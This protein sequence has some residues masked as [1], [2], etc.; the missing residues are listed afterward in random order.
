MTSDHHHED[1]AIVAALRDLSREIIIGNLWSK[2]REDFRI[3]FVRKFQGTVGRGNT[4]APK[5]PGT[6]TASIRELT[7]F[8]RHCNESLAK[9]LLAQKAREPTTS[10]DDHFLPQLLEVYDKQLVRDLTL[11]CVEER[12]RDPAF[13]RDVEAFVAGYKLSA[14]CQQMKATVASEMARVG[15]TLAKDVDA[16]LAV[17]AESGDSGNTGGGA[18]APHRV[19]GSRRDIRVKLDSAFALDQHLAYALQTLSIPE[20]AWQKLR[21]S[22]GAFSHDSGSSDDVNE[23]VFRIRAA[24]VVIRYEVNLSSGSLQ[25][26]AD[27]TFKRHLAAS[28]FHVMDLCASPINAF[29]ST[30]HRAGS[31]HK[32][33]APKADQLTPN[34]FCSAF[35][36]T[37]K[38]FGSLGSALQVV[39][40]E[41][42]RKMD[43][44]V[45][46][47]TGQ[48]LLLTLD[49]PYDEDLCELLFLK[50]KKDIALVEADVAARSR[51]QWLLVLPL[52]WDLQFAHTP[53]KIV[54]ATDV[55]MKGIIARNSGYLRRGYTIEY[56]WPAAL[57]DT[58]WARYD[59][60]FVSKQYTY[61][62]SSTNKLLT[63][64]TETE[65]IGLEPPRTTG[66]AE[67]DKEEQPGVAELLRRFYEP[68]EAGTIEDGS[69]ERKRKRPAADAGARTETDE[70]AVEF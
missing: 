50:L 68:S 26:C 54:G 13:L 32:L 15:G 42:L 53:K 52:W 36:D 64:V 14:R 12:Q 63:G 66:S 44:A 31:V 35:F 60:V 34:H 43:A 2:F 11:K 3:A 6:W 4:S 39:I 29:M 19:D 27:N 22:F 10:D 33:D 8:R 67:A 16:T 46:P 45:I 57:C 20:V 9:W 28:G 58:P 41:L 59:C 38:F 17:P 55:E 30:P 5:I 61:Y 37:D 62:C 24:T 51:V 21:G 1:P 70:A 23:A 56:T 40:P 48:R 25:L 49:V 65:I 69:D 47:L 7:K 18:S